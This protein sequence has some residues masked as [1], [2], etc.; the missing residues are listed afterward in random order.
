MFGIISKKV[1]RLRIL[2][3]N[4]KYKALFEKYEALK[5]SNT[6]LLLELH[7]QN[8]RNQDLIIERQNFLKKH[9][10]GNS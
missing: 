9:D 10:N 7:K 2:E 1:L 5:D 4:N 6:N 3:L 8:N